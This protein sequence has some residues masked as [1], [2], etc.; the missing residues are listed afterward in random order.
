MQGR[1]DH[2]FH[3]AY[4]AAVFVLNAPSGDHFRRDLQVELD[5]V[6]ALADP[7]R[8]I[9]AEIGRRQQ[10]GAGREVE[11]LAVP[12]ENGLRGQPLKKPVSSIISGVT[13]RWNW[14][15]Y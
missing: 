2:P 1:V 13:S 5:A 11:G 10:F 3:L 4:I 6:Y 8:L 14:M 12:V 9:A 15:P 7:V